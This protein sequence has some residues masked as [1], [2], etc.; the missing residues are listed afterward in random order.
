MLVEKMESTIAPLIIPFDKKHFSQFDSFANGTTDYSTL[1][2]TP[3][4]GDHTSRKGRSDDGGL[5][6]R[7]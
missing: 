6:G 2:V 3:F 5:H 7:L 4:E 1:Y